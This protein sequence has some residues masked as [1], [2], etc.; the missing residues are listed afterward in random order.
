MFEIKTTKGVHIKPNT[1][2]ICTE[3]VSIENS[4]PLLKKTNSENLEFLSIVRIFV[5]LFVHKLFRHAN[6]INFGL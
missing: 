1:D 3:N 2:L 5:L 6:N 4:Y